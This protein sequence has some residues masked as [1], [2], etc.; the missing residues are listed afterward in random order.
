MFDSRKYVSRVS[1]KF[2]LVIYL[3]NIFL[4]QVPSQFWNVFMLFIEIATFVY[5]VCVKDFESITYLLAEKSNKT[6]TFE[7]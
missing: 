7:F 2:S 4:T 6:V 3:V 5:I 1:S